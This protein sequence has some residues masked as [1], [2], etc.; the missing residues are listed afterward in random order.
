MT[1]TRALTTLKKARDNMDLDFSELDKLAYRSPAE[2]FGEAGQHKSTQKKEN[3]AEGLPEPATGIRKLQR[4]AAKNK[5][6]KELALEAYQAYQS[7]IRTAEQLRAEILKG[8]KTGESIYTLFMK[9]AEAISRM[10]SDAL[11][12]R[13]LKDDIAAIY[14]EGLLEPAPLQTELAETQERLQKLKEA[15]L[16]EPDNRNIQ[17]AIQAHEHRA[18]ELHNLIQNQERES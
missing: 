1:T 6:E 9:A 15:A 14:G 2:P 16:R 17:A 4:K 8:A 5:E 10:T 7:N 13:Q 18:G 3:P 11:F 12:Y